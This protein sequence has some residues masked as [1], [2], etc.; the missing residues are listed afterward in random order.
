MRSMER[1]TRSFAPTEPF[2]QLSTARFASLTATRT[3]RGRDRERLIPGPSQYSGDMPL[4]DVDRG[5]FIEKLDYETEF[6]RDWSRI[7]EPDQRAIV[8]EINRV[9]D[10]LLTS[11]DPNWGS[12]TNTSVEGG[13]RNPVTGEPG[14]WTGTPF[15]S[16]LRGLQS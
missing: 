13:K 15:S 16:N 1:C 7:S 2:S 4:Y 3:E 12:V 10:G 6:Q 8:A 11:P 14:D 5:R 9:L